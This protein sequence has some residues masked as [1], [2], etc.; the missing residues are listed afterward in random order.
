M[1][2]FLF[3]IETTAREL[4][5]KLLMAVKSCKPGRKIYVG[6]Q[7]FIR[8]LSFFLRGGV[9]YGK[10]LFGKPYFSDTKY[11]ER[12]KRR[13]FKLVHLNEEGAVVPGDDKVFGQLLKQA[14][15]PSVLSE[16]DFLITW[17]EWQKRFNKS[18]ENPVASIIATGH[19][20]FDL[21]S[22][23]YQSYF[24]DEVNALNKK[25]GNYILVNTAFSYSN[26]G[27]GGV[28][29]IFKPTLSYDAK[30][31]E[32]REYRFKRWHNQMQSVAGIVYLVNK[33]SIK[34]PDTNIII[35][36]HPSE[37]LEYY[38]K[39]FDG[40]ANVLIIY[41]GAVTPWILGSKVLIHNGCTTAIEATL[42]GK[43]VINYS[44]NFDQ[45]FDIY[46][47]TICG[48]TFNN[49]ESVISEVDKSYL[50]DCIVE[51]PKNKRAIDLFKNFTDNDTSASVLNVLEEAD[52]LT[53][54]RKVSNVNLTALRIMSLV[55]RGFLVLKYSYLFLVGRKKDKADYLKRFGNLEQASI[56]KKIDSL[57]QILDKNVK[58]KYVGR[59]LTVLEVDK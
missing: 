54:R 36:P 41:E 46:L 16:D 4:D 55:H 11:Y 18:Y 52:N 28:G 19:P 32:H 21:Y 7:Q 44:P 6:D 30:T 20:R 59:F 23:K 49:V 51:L 53:D 9:F 38:K 14:E 25:Y 39:I 15:R 10:H 48:K 35:R 22:P 33:L 37:D 3:P 27:E 58:V 13:N 12:L 1:T 47:A 56:G 8:M 57:N 43:P 42:A 29:F 31:I 34:Y 5:Q 50:S 45:D 24:G 2:N 40:I 26:N 17:G